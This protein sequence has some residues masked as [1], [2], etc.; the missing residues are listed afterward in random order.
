MLTVE[1]F[2]ERIFRKMLAVRAPAPLLSKAR[3]SSK[4]PRQ[5][6]SPPLFPLSDEPKGELADDPEENRAV[7]CSRLT[8]LL[9]K[10]SSD[11]SLVKVP[12]RCLRDAILLNA[13]RAGEN[14]REV[15]AL[16]SLFEGVVALCHALQS[17]GAPGPYESVERA[18]RLRLF[19]CV[20][21][22]SWK[23]RPGLR[24][25]AVRRLR[26]FAVQ[27][28]D[29]EREAL[30]AKKKASG[31][32]APPTSFP[33]LAAAPGRTTTVVTKDAASAPSRLPRSSSSTSSR[34]S[35]D[36]SPAAAAS[37]L[38]RRAPA[39]VHAAVDVSS[40]RATYAE[41]AKVP[42]S[43]MLPVVSALADDLREA[44]RTHRHDR[45]ALPSDATPKIL[46]VLDDDEEDERVDASSS[47][48]TEKRAPTASASPPEP[49]V[50]STPAAVPSGWHR[51]DAPTPGSTDR[52]AFARALEAHAPGSN[53][54]PNAR[55]PEAGEKPVGRDEFDALMKRL[56]L[57]T[58]A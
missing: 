53:P 10:A 17:R 51:F 46:A 12:L 20:A 23:D 16:F 28:A 49:R 9:R 34:G 52:R 54:G 47:S 25:R 35:Q 4:P 19:L 43:K 32:N 55:T 26:A 5:D 3:V 21:G 39:G 22:E 33:S 31:A 45:F 38:F 11:A 42:P 41:L 37:F 48:S 50:P 15:E 40:W 2:S 36:R 13:T 30:R 8:D 14:A 29:H 24:A 44:E 57:A 58:D 56:E 7:A 27:E 18:V 6:R 1:D